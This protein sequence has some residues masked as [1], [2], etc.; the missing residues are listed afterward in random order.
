MAKIT[1]IE[2]YARSNRPQPVR[3]RHRIY[4]DPTGPPTVGIDDYLVTPEPT[5]S[6]WR[7]IALGVGLGV[8]ALVCGT[9]AVITIIYAGLVLKWIL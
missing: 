9:V 3:G 6:L 1:N 5:P 7:R 4:D 8:A 2:H